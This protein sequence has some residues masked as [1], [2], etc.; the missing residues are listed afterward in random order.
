M[1]LTKSGLKQLIKEELSIIIESHPSGMEVP[2][3]FIRRGEENL[4]SF[5]ERYPNV[6]GGLGRAGEQELSLA[7]ANEQYNSAMGGSGW[8]KPGELERILLQLLN[9]GWEHSFFPEEE[10]EET[11]L[12]LGTPPEDP[13]APAGI[14]NTLRRTLKTGE[15]F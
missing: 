2:E 11:P 12:R 3:E 1:K 10:P 7:F 15:R 6:I 13:L 14:R 8:V 4:Q 9:D 5:K